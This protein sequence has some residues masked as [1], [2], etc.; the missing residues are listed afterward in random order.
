MG[1]GAGPE[2]VSLTVNGRVHGGQQ[3]VVGAQIQLYVAGNAGNGSAASALLTKTV[4]SGADGGFSITG[5]YSCPSATSQVYLVATGGNPGLGTG[6]NNP[7]LAMMT[8]LGSCG[9]LTPTQFIWIDE[10]TTAAAAWALAP[11]TKDLTDIGASATNYDGAKG[12]DGKATQSGL[13]NAFLNAQLVADTS[14]G[15]VA[16][17]G[18]GLTTEPGKIYALADAVASCVNSDGTTG[19]QPLFTAATVS[20]GTAPKTTWDALMNI[21]K[22]PANNVGGVF[23]AIG[24]QPPFA[25]TLTKAPNDWT[26]SLTVTGAGIASPESL[27]FDSQGN[28]WVADYGGALTALTPQGAALPGSPFGTNLLYEDFG[29]AV[30]PSDDVWVTVEEYPVHSPTRG[31]LVRFSGVSSGATL[32][33]SKTF[34]DATINYPYAV[35]ADSDGK[36]FVANYS[37]ISGSTNLVTVDPGTSTYKAID[38]GAN[39]GSSVALAADTAHGVWVTS[40]SNASIAHVD[41]TGKVT[42]TTDCCGPT[43]GVAVDSAGNAWVADYADSDA[44]SDPGGAVTEFG[45]DDSTKLEFITGGGIT[46]PSH[47][48]IDAAQNVWVTNLHTTSSATKSESISEIGGIKSASPGTPL[49]PA[50]GYGLDAGLLVPYGLAVDPSGNVWVSNTGANSVVM[51]FG[52]AEPTKTP[53]TVAPVE[54]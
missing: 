24:P 11:F 16:T 7:A 2:P 30:D 50:A 4:T 34:S 31:S 46:V 37:V 48:A 22:H 53:M 12:T 20:G 14:T 9:K 35:A 43:D 39:I 28:V 5:D 45:A 8:A 15:N 19:C 42:L 54:P 29:L 36:L 47:V 49:T 51:F 18:S 44:A 6:G 41:A 33:T 3:P 10:V 26:L 23:A 13:L 40:E 32:G 38:L 1:A 27:A 25:T 17:L 21:V 52:M